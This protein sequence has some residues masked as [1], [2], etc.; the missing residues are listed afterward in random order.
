MTNREVRRYW[1]V[2]RDKPGLLLAMMR[3]LAGEAHISFEGDLSRC[4]FPS[5]LNP[6]AM[7]T[8][9]LKRATSVPRG[10]FVVL[11]LT[12]NTIDSILEVVLPDRRYMVDIIHIQ[13]EQGGV[14]QFG[15][16]DNFHPECIVAYT[17]VPTEFLNQ[18]QASGVIR[19]WA[20]PPDD[21]RR[22]HG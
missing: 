20:E 16:Y 17:G 22:W 6:S 9:A 5:T 8:P 19:S 3:A 18:L 4:T 13:I 14:L 15:A 7:E 2:A 21:A 11:P 10:D 1:I 12:P